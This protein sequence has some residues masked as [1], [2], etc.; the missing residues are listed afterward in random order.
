MTS[1]GGRTIARVSVRV[2]PDTKGFRAQVEAELDSIPDKTVTVEVDWDVDEAELKAKLA[3][4]RD[5]ITIPV[6]F[7]VRKGKLL[8]EEAL[9]K[10]AIT[11]PA[12]VDSKKVVDWDKVF[13][14]AKRVAQESR[15]SFTG[16]QFD[17]TAAFKKLEEVAAAQRA[18]KIPVELSVPNTSALGKDSFLLAPF[19]RMQQEATAAFSKIQDAGGK[20]AARITSA[21]TSAGQ[22]ISSQ[23]RLIRSTAGLVGGAIGQ[24][25]VL[26]GRSMKNAFVDGTTSSNRFLRSLDGLGTVVG[27]GASTMLSFGKSLGSV[28]SVMAEMGSAVIGV[29]SAVA[30]VV[31]SLARWVAIGALIGG[32]GAAIT[33]AWGFA[34]TAIAAVPA[35][36]GLIAAPIAAIK[37]GMDGIK[38]A[39][40][41]LDPAFKHMQ[42]TISDTFEK[43]LTPV[44][45]NLAK[46]L[47]PTLEA[48]LNNV[49]KSLVGMAD[50][51]GT[52]LTSAK[53]LN[54]VKTLFD[55]VATALSQIDL[56]PL[57]D[58][59]LRLAG[60]Q[61][62]LSALTTTVNELGLAVQSIADNKFLDTAFQGLESVLTGVTRAFQ[63]LVNN[64]IRLFAAA[65][66]GIR[67]FLDDITSFFGKFDW[68]SLG[69]SVGG[70]FRGLGEAINSIPQGT[71]DSITQSFQGLSTALQSEEFAL[72]IRGIAEVVP[73]AVDAL[74]LLVDTIGFLGRAFAT[75][76]ALT[77]GFAEV[78]GDT[79][80]A[81]GLT[82][83]AGDRARDSLK[84]LQDR[85]NG[86]KPPLVDVSTG[87][88][89]VGQGMDEFGRDVSTLIN[90]PDGIQGF[91]PAIKQHVVDPLTTLPQIF[92]ETG[93]KLVP[94]IKPGFDALGPAA[95]GGMLALRETVA[96][97]AAAA[98]KALFDG[99][100]KMPTVASTATAP[101]PGSVDDKLSTLPNVGTTAA[102]G[103]NTSFGEGLKP[104]SNT[105]L[106]GLLPVQGAAETALAPLATQSIPQA[107]QA[108]V[109]AANAAFPGLGTAF[110]TGLAALA[111]IVDTAFQVL[112]TT[113]IP[114]AMQG[115]GT[116]VT[117]GFTTILA[118]AFTT[119]FTGLGT[120]I[121]TGFAT[122]VAPAFLLGFQTMGTGINVA[123]LTLIAPAFAAGMTNLGLS[124]TT[125]FTAVNQ[126]FTIGFIALGAGIV[127]SFTTLLQPAVVT[128]MTNLGTAVTTGF[129]TINTAFTTGFTNVKTSIDTAMTNLKTSIDTGF[130]GATGAATTGMANIKAAVD[131]GGTDINTSITTT[132]ANFIKA[133][134]DSATRAAGAM[135]DVVAAVVKAVDV[136]ALTPVG[137]SLIEGMANGMIQGI[138]AVEDA[139]RQAVQ[140][141][142]AAA[143]AEAN[144]NSPSKLF[145][146]QVG[147]PLTEGQALGQL[148]NIPMVED[149]ARQSVRAAMSAAQDE[150]GT[151]SS[152]SLVSALSDS[153][154][155]FS[156]KVAAELTASKVPLIAF[157]HQTV[158]GQKVVEDSVSQVVGVWEK[159]LLTGTRTA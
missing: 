57:L 85:M 45:Q 94:A 95:T 75:G 4:I 97:E 137:K 71:I 146:D 74:T 151:L 134:A 103:L 113:N 155:A 48:G 52:F 157:S 76:K 19:R 101:V 132:M 23:F 118:P 100:T 9:A 20:S 24:S 68:T 50:K 7:D 77:F 56:V 83:G 87:F 104:M 16:K 108:M 143:N 112:S 123:F 80:D 60:N 47:F 44:F 67:T 41:A 89:K 84:A 31:L 96:R 90:S 141:A 53:G 139:A 147:K 30:G 66:P 150:V 92:T 114:L 3:A 63:G 17:W 35:A 10:E 51:V 124:V 86:I 33:A 81:L 142:V 37:I 79:T 11:I 78:L 64:G 138:R 105:T 140:K 121:T 25:F 59:F 88:S 93:D 46:N 49:A 6:D 42:K 154:H 152:L 2:T 27:R 54:E 120:A 149:A 128:G 36:I 131:T 129:T 8:A 144:V 28:V 119:G 158:L 130:V 55:N 111:P 29:G 69:E 109:D 117:A 15:F 34:S 122:N 133:I 5:R 73:L 136:N 116:A 107:T 153:T 32:A 91:E 115:M 13:A 106:A 58:G 65:A 26:A 102:Q 70:A 18:L 14:E 21:F 127:A 135:K 99:L 126:A 22:K 43:G 39:A 1:G 159:D 148:Q 40:K 38:K 61:A 72:G 145:R 12:K 156:A 98:T 82:T 125:G 62:A 110:Q